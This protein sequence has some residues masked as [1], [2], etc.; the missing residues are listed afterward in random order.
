MSMAALLLAA[1]GYAAWQVLGKTSKAK[2]AATPTK[3][4]TPPV[5]AAGWAQP[6]VHPVTAPVAI[7]NAIVVYTA[8][9]GVL[10]LRILNPANGATTWSAV[11]T[12]SH[13][14]PGEPFEVAHKGNAVY[15]YAP[16]GEARLGLATLKAVDVS[17]K[18]LLWSS[19]KQH[20]FA[21][22]PR[23]CSD[24][25]AL[26]VSAYTSGV[27]ATRLRVTLTN[28][29]EKVVSTQGGRALGSG[30]TDTGSRA[31]EYV[32]HIDDTTGRIVWKADVATLFGSAVSSDGGWDWDPYGSVYVGWIAAKRNLT[33]PTATF[34]KEQT[35]GV[36][37]ATGKRV[38]KK[39]GVYGCPVQ[40]LLDNG[41][42]IPVRCLVKGTVTFH[43]GDNPTFVGLDVT[44]QGF[45]PV[46][47]ATTWSA[48]L[49]NAPAALGIASA[50]GLVRV[51]GHV[52]ALADAAGHTKVLDLATGKI[53]APDT[54]T[55]AWCLS[56]DA[57]WDWA[58]APTFQGKKVKFLT[59]GLATPCSETRKAMAPTDGTLAGVGASAGGFFVWSSTDGLHGLKVS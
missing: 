43:P 57:T 22:M 29:A 9:S 55:A 11:A 31:P 6:K 33:A 59:Q 30:I 48:K 12:P 39:P 2:P 34:D 36:D 16:A 24:R 32:E 49:G 25:L 58:Y 53:S 45:N 56:S 15:F 21:D 20:S 19:K 7:G 13:N 27:K 5:R 51:S 4:A 52:F 42:P 54:K 37:A 26:C 44:M 46:T 17:T 40:G 50:N 38:W 1:G 8:D 3:S 35:I 18:K 47:G 14:T 23:L 41:K 10:T 28:G